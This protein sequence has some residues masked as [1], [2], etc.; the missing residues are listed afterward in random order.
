M[1]LNVRATIKSFFS[2][3]QKL[4][5][6]NWSCTRNMWCSR[7]R[8]FADLVCRDL[9]NYGTTSIFDFGKQSF[10]SSTVSRHSYLIQLIT[11]SLL[12]IPSCFWVCLHSAGSQ[13]GNLHQA[14]VTTSRVTYY[15][16]SASPHV[17]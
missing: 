11:S 4:S 12:C 17:A 2:G 1:C 9:R 10:F 7:T 15:I 8:N 16:H 14:F 3:Y 6:G 13:Y 5:L